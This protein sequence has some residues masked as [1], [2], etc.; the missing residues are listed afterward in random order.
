LTDWQL[1]HAGCAGCAGLCR[2]AVGFD[3][4]TADADA[5]TPL[6]TFALDPV[7]NNP[8]VSSIGVVSDDGEIQFGVDTSEASGTCATAAARRCHSPLPPLPLP[9]PLPLAAATRRCHSP[10]P[11]PL[12][13]P[14]TTA[15]T[16]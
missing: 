15:A 13:L 9:L 10:L 14:L 5:D 4:S 16:G 3:L 2:A 12:P 11:L 8:W 7:S 6:L 1:T